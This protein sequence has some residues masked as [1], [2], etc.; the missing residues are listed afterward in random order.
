MNKI[1]YQKMEQMRNDVK[2]AG[3]FIPTNRV[4]EM[5]SELSGVID[6]VDKEEGG[7]ALIYDDKAKEWIEF[8]K[9]RGLSIEAD[10]NCQRVSIPYTVS[11]MG[12]SVGEG[13]ISNE[14]LPHDELIY[15]I[16]KNI[17][18]DSVLSKLEE[19]EMIP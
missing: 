1:I 16:A 19:I 17:D 18:A 5:L 8:L 13:T 12:K 7:E 15:K 9:T 14:G 10:D 4:L 2:T 11:Y 6:A 3:S